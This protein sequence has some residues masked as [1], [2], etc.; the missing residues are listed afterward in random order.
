MRNKLEFEGFITRGTEEIKPGF[1][2]FGIAMDNS[3]KINGVWNKETVF[4]DCLLFGEAQKQNVNKGDFVYVEGDF[5]IGSWTGQDGQKRATYTLF[6]KSYEQRPKPGK[7]AQVAV[8]GHR[9]MPIEQTNSFVENSKAFFKDSED[10]EP[11]PF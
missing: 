4:V 8:V 10:D 1:H 6:I 2:K 9:T 3:Q 11:T 7:Q 5:K